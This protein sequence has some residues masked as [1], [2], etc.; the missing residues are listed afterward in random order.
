MNDWVTW[1][2]NRGVYSERSG[3]IVRKPTYSVVKTKHDRGARSTIR[4]GMRGRGRE[5]K[6]G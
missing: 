6:S 3:F 5:K 2:L 1:E 4:E